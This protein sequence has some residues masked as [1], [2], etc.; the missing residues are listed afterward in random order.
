M[1]TTTLPLLLKAFQMPNTRPS[2]NCC[3]TIKGIDARKG[4]AFIVDANEAITIDPRALVC[5]KPIRQY[6]RI[7]RTEVTLTNTILKPKKSK[8]AP[9]IGAQI[10]GMTCCT[11][12]V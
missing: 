9:T 7:Q 6:T 1:S 10:T 3:G 8:K 12:E 5:V 11:A 2:C 4:R